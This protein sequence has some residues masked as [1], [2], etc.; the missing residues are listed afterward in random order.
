MAQEAGI[1]ALKEK[2]YVENGRQMVF[3]EAKYLKEKLQELG[4][5]VFSV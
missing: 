5:E 1:A 2:E 3:E 4:M